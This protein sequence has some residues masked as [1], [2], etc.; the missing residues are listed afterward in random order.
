MSSLDRA[1]D[2]NPAVAHSA[3]NVPDG[4]VLLDEILPRRTSLDQPNSIP[5]ENSG[6]VPGSP[7]KW[8][9]HK[10][11]V[12]ST[13]TW[14]W[15][16]PRPLGD[17]AIT[18]GMQ[19]RAVHTG[20]R[21]LGGVAC[22]DGGVHLFHSENVDPLRMLAGLSLDFFTSIE[23]TANRFR[24]QTAV[25]P[26]ILLMTASPLHSEGDDRPRVLS[27]LSKKS[28]LRWPSENLLEG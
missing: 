13:S 11:M 19:L 16:A 7:S 5:F 1:N 17:E 23:I 28:I 8:Q 21:S 24:L 26:A 22:S 18:P 6:T 15:D 12:L 4:R 25:S 2:T 20:P 9:V 3:C 14:R 10:A 27:Y